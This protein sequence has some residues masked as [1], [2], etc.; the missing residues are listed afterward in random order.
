MIF[1]LRRFLPFSIILFLHFAVIDY[2]SLIFS[3]TSL[4]WLLI[5]D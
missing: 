5:T 1:S 2:I 3:A 4:H